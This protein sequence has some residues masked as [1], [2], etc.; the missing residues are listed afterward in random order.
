[1]TSES[2]NLDSVRR[3]KT[4][5]TLGCAG[6]FLA[7]LGASL[8]LSQW[9]ILEKKIVTLQRTQDIRAAEARY[10]QIWDRISSMTEDTLLEDNILEKMQVIRVFPFCVDAQRERIY[11]TNRS[12]DEV[13]ETYSKAFQQM[14]WR[15]PTLQ[16]YESQ[17]GSV[18]VNS[19]VKQDSLPVGWLGYRTLYSIRLS[20]IEPTIGTCA[21]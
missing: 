19:V 5:S 4:L 15:I 21:G 10:D 1:M 16:D 17:T 20:Y 7:C 6:L 9:E 14:G 13:L 3:R 11:G 8:L 2:K 12:I 18:D